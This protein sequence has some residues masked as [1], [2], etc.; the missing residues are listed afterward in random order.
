LGKRHKCAIAPPKFW[1]TQTT[2][3]AAIACANMGP[4]PKATAFVS[5]LSVLYLATEANTLRAGAAIATAAF[6][7]DAGSA[8]AGKADAAKTHKAML[9]PE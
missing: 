2:R 6:P 7:R 8:C 9:L 3:G 5:Q 4:L 1:V